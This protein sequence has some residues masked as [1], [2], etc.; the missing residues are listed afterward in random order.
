MANLILRPNSDISTSNFEKEPSSQSNFYSL[1]N[2][3]S[4]DWNT[5]YFYSHNNAAVIYLG[6]ELP[7]KSNN[8]ITKIT[9]HTNCVYQRD[10]GFDNSG[11]V[12]FG[13]VLNGEEHNN[14]VS[15]GRDT[16][17]DFTGEFAPSSDMKFSDISTLQSRFGPREA[18]GNKFYI[19]CTQMYI[20]IEYTEVTPPKEFIVTV[21]ASHISHNLP[22]TIMEGDPV[23]G[24]FTPDTGFLLPSAITVTMGDM[25]ISSDQ[26]VYDNASGN[27]SIANVT[28]DIQISI[29]GVKQQFTITTIASEG[30][31][32]TPTITVEY[33][34]NFEIIYTANEGYVVSNV[35]VDNS[36]V[37]IT[38]AYAFT[39]ITSDHKIEVQFTKLS[40]TNIVVAR[41]DSLSN[42]SL[43][44]ELI[45]SDSD[46][47]SI[48]KYGNLVVFELIE[49]NG[50]IQIESNGDI[51]TNEIKE[52]QDFGS[53]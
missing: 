46:R 39:N 52:V 21:K 38:G 25:T 32:I 16:Y 12:T 17:Q 11:Y 53:N 15:V 18:S 2:E 42:I 51:R 13:F 19:K 35:L 24:I 7:E 22:S 31:T 6:S 8:Q 4:P 47:V 50:N 45:E 26:Y 5:T 40:P 36:P 49:G 23:F 10:S 20:D 30:G 41:I 43:V 28:G 37:E 14:R 3:A 1:V 48:Q 34:D 33:G 27:F 9:V 44:G 29:N